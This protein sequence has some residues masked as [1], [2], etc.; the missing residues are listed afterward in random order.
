MIVTTG[1][2]SAT[3]ARNKAKEYAGRLDGSFVEREKRSVEELI[4][5]YGDDVLVVGAEKAVLHPKNGAKPFF[6]HPNSAMVRRKQWQQTGH[7]P[8]IEAAQLKQGDRF[9]DCTFG[10]GADSIIAKLAV[11]AKGDVVGVEANPVIAFLVSEGL[12]LWSEGDPQFLQ[13]MREIKVICAEHYDYLQTV[14]DKSY[15]VVYFDPMFE[16]SLPSAGIAGLKSFAVHDDLNQTVINEACRV[17]RRRVV[18]KDHWKSSRFEALG[19]HVIKRQHAA[20]HYSY[21]DVGDKTKKDETNM[22]EMNEKGRR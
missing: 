20:F 13:A 9:L 22:F 6:F 19:F 17:A 15:D 10:L 2:K 7:D 4:S 3:Q 21:R 14:A 5:V 12:K 16:Q 8:L 18:L 11:G 1:L